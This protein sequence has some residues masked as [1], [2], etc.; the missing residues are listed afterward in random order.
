[1]RQ[2]IIG[3][4]ALLVF[5]ACPTLVGAQ[6][7]V[8]TEGPTTLDDVLVEQRLETQVRRFTEQLSRP[9]LTRGL[10]RW[11]G[12]VCIGVYNL[13]REVAEQIADG[14]AHT[15][16]RLGVPIADGPCA[17]NIM[18]INAVDASEV[19]A[20]WVHQEYREFRPNISRAALSRERLSQFTGADVP[21]RWWAIS[22]PAY[23]D[24]FTGTRNLVNGPGQG[25][26]EVRTAMNR[27]RHTRDDL[28]RLT[29]IVD[30]DQ[31]EGVSPE[32][33]IAYLSMVSF[34]QV[35]MQ[36]DM[37]GFDSILNLFRTRPAIDGL[38][39]WDEAYIRGLYGVPR[40]LQIKQELLREE[41]VERLRAPAMQEAA[42]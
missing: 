34:S 22:R 14:L 15:G 29:I 37:S 26:I 38:T 25:I 21:V 31:I 10:A 36:A 42:N 40:D 18:I 5:G 16:H 11:R 17:P 23:F 30:A 28:Q 1:M 13:Q 33:L 4:L 41:M 6:S 8:L 24:I 3:A 2:S 32:N 19:A 12:P 39:P 27:D 9:V 7:G 35:D 20:R